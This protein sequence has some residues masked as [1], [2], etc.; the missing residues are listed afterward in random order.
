MDD[1]FVHTE[2]HITHNHC[3]CMI[4]K[5]LQDAG[6]TL[7]EKCEFYKNS[8]RFL[9]QI[10]DST[11]I[12]LDLVKIKVTDNSLSFLKSSTLYGYDKSSG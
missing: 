7:N 11:S 10:I 8:M 12:R 5:Q 3:L 9:G 4:L 1:I 2:D 6:L